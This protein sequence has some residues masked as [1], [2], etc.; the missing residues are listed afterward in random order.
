MGGKEVHRQEDGRGWKSA[1]LLGC[2]TPL[3]NN[4]WQRRNSTVPDAR[5]RAGMGTAGRLFAPTG[6]EWEADKALPYLIPLRVLGP[7]RHHNGHDSWG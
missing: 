3:S 7:G 5:T 6:S 1:Q 4:T 2:S